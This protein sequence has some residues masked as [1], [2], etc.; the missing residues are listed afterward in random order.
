MMKTMKAMPLLKHMYYSYRH[1]TKH[2]QEQ[3]IYVFR[4]WHLQ[5]TCSEQTRRILYPHVPREPQKRNKKHATCNNMKTKGRKLKRCM[6]NKSSVRRT[7]LNG[8]ALN[9]SRDRR[10]VLNGSVLIS[11]PELFGT[12]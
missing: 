11:F 1:L 5:Q 7:V 2:I 10:T 8:S 9:V 12:I 3:N 6:D 4:A